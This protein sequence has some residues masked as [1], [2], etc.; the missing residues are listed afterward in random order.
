MQKIDLKDRK[1]IYHLDLDS[2]QSFTSIGKKVGLTKDNVAYRVKKLQQQGIITN[3]RTYISFAPLFYLY[4]RIYFSFQNTNPTIKKEIIEYLVNYKETTYVISLE[5]MHDLLIIIPVKNSLKLNTFFQNIQLR[6]GDYIAQQPASIYLIVSWYGLNFL[7]DTKEP[8]RQIVRGLDERELI[9]ITK[10]FKP[11][12]IDKI[13]FKILELLADN[14]R[15]PTTEIATT[16]HTTVTV[17]HHRIKKL[18][19]LGIIAGYGITLEPK[20][21]GYRYYHIDIYLKKLTR[22]YEIIDYIQKNPHLYSIE[23][24]LGNTADLELEFYLKNIEQLHEI[25]EDMSLKFPD[26]IKTY[27]YFSYLKTHKINSMP[28]IDV[29]TPYFSTS[30]ALKGIKTITS[31]N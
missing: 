18:K 17:I 7:L 16:L 1:I 23:K 2:R 14:A 30:K 8:K 6:F 3:F 29:K 27:N 24:A 13:D 5:G 31:I 20:P 4:T 10:H 15:I 22:R 12:K 19:E 21:L 11:L 26:S 25:M 9:K 28:N